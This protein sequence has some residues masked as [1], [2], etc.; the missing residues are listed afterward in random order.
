[1]VR[2]WC[3]FEESICKKENKRPEDKGFLRK[4][5]PMFLFGEQEPEE[6]M[7]ARW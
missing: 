3:R 4:R 5:I 1:M 7:V 2:Y 6:G